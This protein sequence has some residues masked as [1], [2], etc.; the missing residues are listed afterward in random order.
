MKAISGNIKISPAVQIIT[1]YIIISASFMRHVLNFLREKLGHGG[2]EKLIWAAFIISGLL[3][4]RYIGGRI[5]KGR[6]FLRLLLL[7]VIGAGIAWHASTMP[8]IEERIHL[9]LFGLLGFFLA[10]DN[11]AG[12]LA[13]AF[14]LSVLGSLLVAALDEIFQYYLPTRVGEIKDVISGG[15]GGIYGAVFYLIVNFRR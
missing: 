8:I 5:I 7:I 15:I 2:L 13:P 10:R 14:L 12:R 1:L 9:V 11:D 3:F 4:L 6:Q